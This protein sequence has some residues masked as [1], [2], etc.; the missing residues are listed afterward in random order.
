MKIE[1]GKIVKAQGIKGEVKI[2]CYLDD[3]SMLKN[4]KEMYIGSAAYAVKHLRC[5]GAFCY[6]L[7]DGIEDR[8]LA[9]S[10]K[11]RTVYADK[12]N[13]AMPDNRYFISDLIG[14]KVLLDDG[15]VVGNVREVLQYGS[16]D[17]FV[18]INNGKS[19]SF[20]FLN[21]LIVSV[22]IAGKQIVLGSKRFTEVAVYED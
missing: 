12:E 20:P 3:S 18:C 11:N 19:V 15:S 2:A 4:V 22:N 6:A 8:N 7:F 13:V 9:E 10:L 17:V 5:D 14:C 16:A 1:I 21:D